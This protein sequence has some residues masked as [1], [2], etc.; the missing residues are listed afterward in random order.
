MDLTAQN[1][2][3]RN[4]EGLLDTLLR[5]AAQYQRQLD[6]KC[7]ASC[8]GG[9]YHVKNGVVWDQDTKLSWQQEVSEQ[10]FTWQQAKDHAAALKLDGGGWRF[11]RWRS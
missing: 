2:A 11:P 6:P 8:I 7:R 4:R 9:R 10:T 5:D 3:L 1:S